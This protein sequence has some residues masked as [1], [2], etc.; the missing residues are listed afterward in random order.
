[1][2]G[3][4]IPSGITLHGELCVAGV[5]FGGPPYWDIVSGK[6]DSNFS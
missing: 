6:K 2:L 5:H 3:C 1:M 4:V